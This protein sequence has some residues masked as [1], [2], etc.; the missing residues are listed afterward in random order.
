[1]GTSAGYMPPSGGDWNSLKRQMGMLLGNPEKRNM[2]LGKF[3]KAIGGAENFSSSSKPKGGVGGG[4]KSFR[5]SSAR[6]TSQNVLSF[7]SDVHNLGLEKT[8]QDR[9]LDFKNK[10]LEEIKDLL[11]DYFS[12]PS[13]DT[14]SDASSRAIASVLDELFSNIYTE[15][16]LESCF[17]EIISTEKS[18]LILCGFYEKYIFELFAKVFYEDRTLHDNQ[19][20]AND[21]LEIAQDTIKAKVAT[22]KCS[23]NLKDIDFKGQ[24]GA[25]FVQG[26]LKDILEIL[27]DIE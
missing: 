13:S 18:E 8:I 17:S 4:A 16:E 7:F 26:I 11:I 1:M 12:E 10:N 5:S 22:F 21:I 15:E 14:D 25:D 3:I 23:Y 24:D 19:N 27:E 20:D 6:Q 9:G 2:V